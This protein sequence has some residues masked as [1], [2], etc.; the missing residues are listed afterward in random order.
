MPTWSLAARLLIAA[1]FALA[2]FLGLTGLALDKAS[3]ERAET[4]L[5]DRLEGQ[6][7]D[8]M[9]GSEL[10]VGGTLALPDPLPDPRYLRPGSGLYAAV[11]SAEFSWESDSAL[12]YSLPWVSELGP[13]EARFAGPIKTDAGE[14]YLLSRGV[15]WEHPRGDEVKFTISIAQERS[16]LLRQVHSFRRTLWTWLGG[17][18]LVLLLVLAGVLRW[19]LNPLRSLERELRA[20]E[21][22]EKGRIDG[23][24]PTEVIGLTSNLNALIL[25]EREGLDRYRRTLGDLAH[26]LKTPLAVLQSKVESAPDDA[27]LREEVREQVQ[28]MSDLVQYQLQ[29]AA[30]RGHQT[31]SAPLAVQPIAEDIVASLE[32]AHAH[33]AVNCGFEIDPD[34]RFFGERGDLLELL[35]NLLENAFK[36]CRHSVLLTAEPLHKARGRRAGLKLRVEDDGPGIAPEQ[37]PELLKRGVRG[38]ERVQ[39]HGIGLSI[40]QDI[41]R[42]YRGELKVSRAEPLGGARFDIEFPPR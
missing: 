26:S 8:F 21:A 24:Y 38:D 20:I 18:A 30:T 23:D 35:G 6:V 2:A 40:V 37:V 13:N 33:K 3:L 7:L 11:L 9:R 36:W 10:T 42:A 17:A 31:L 39:G 25:N 29:R 14:V 5:K 4:A 16:A 34:A 1:S 27:T 22:G 41:V 32:K 12:G 19:S 15:I 28:R